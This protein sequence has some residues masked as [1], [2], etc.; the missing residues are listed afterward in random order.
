M[1]P[2]SALWFFA[3]KCGVA[4]AFQMKT[5]PSKIGGIKDYVFGY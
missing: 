5:Q 4:F 2:R 3:R 1:L